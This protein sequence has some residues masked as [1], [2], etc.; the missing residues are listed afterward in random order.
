MIAPHLLTVIA[1]QYQLPLPALQAVIQVESNQR[2]FTQNKP[3]ILFERHIFYKQLK[4]KGLNAN[5]IALRFPQICSP[6]SGGYFGGIREHARLS[7]AKQIHTES[8][9]ESA[10]WGLFQIMGFH[11][12][13]LGYSSAEEFETLMSLSE[14]E[15]LDAFLRFISHPQNKRMLIALQNCDFTRF[16]ALYNGPAYHKNQ[17]DTKMRQAYA[18]F[19]AA[20]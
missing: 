16:A 9:I 18:H 5:A 6:K 11:W 17:Y 7:Q 1:N 20:H 10:S 12:Q 14:I 2:G 19:S 8:A 3:T 4:K 13:L 15:Q